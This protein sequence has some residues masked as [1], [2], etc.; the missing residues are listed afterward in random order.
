MVAIEMAPT[1]QLY[2][3]S[4]AGSLLLWTK[5]N[6]KNKKIHGFGD[7]LEQLFPSS[8]RMQYLLQFLVFVVFGGCVGV[9]AVGPFTQMQALAGG[10]AW[11]RLAAKD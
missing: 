5:L 2:C 4:A 8:P 6:A 7:V 1:W 3:F 9:W 11:S 10:M